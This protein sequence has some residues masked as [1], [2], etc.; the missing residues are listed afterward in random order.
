VKFARLALALAAS[1][2]IVGGTAYVVTTQAD[3]AP[4]AV[5]QGPAAGDDGAY[6]SVVHVCISQHNESA[7][8][9]EEHTNPG[10][11][12]NC[13]AGYVQAEI[14]A[15]YLAPS[16]TLTLAPAPSPDASATPSPT[17]TATCTVTQN[18]QGASGSDPDQITS[19]ACSG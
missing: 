2:V 8:Y 4:A 6:T 3:A 17:A 1:A 12:G 14:N 7:G 16:F 5:A 18:A 9:V 13:A 11:I 19:I 10:T 15:P